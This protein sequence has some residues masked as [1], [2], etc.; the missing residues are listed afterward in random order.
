MTKTTRRKFSV[1]FKAKVALEALKERNTIESIAQKYELHPTQ[2]NTWKREFIANASLVFGGDEAERSA[3]QERET[4]VEKLY[5]QIGMLK[6]QNDFLKK[7]L[8]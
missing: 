6:V 7:K 8:Q 4:E 3:R 2:V 5:A 1:E